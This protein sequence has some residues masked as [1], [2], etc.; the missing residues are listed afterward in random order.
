MWDNKS[1]YNG[2]SI[3]PYSEHTYKQAPFEDCTQEKY[4]ELYDSLREVDV[5]KIIEIEDNTNLA[6]E[7][8]CAGGA[9]E[10]T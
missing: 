7:L 1:I 3:L 10:I 8:A 9:C 6:G 5:S 4:I 2:L